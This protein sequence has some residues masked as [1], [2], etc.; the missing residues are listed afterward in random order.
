[1]AQR[2]RIQ[3]IGKCFSFFIILIVEI[4]LIPKRHVPI[5]GFIVHGKSKMVLPIPN[6]CNANDAANA[7]GRDD[8]TNQDNGAIIVQ[9]TVCFHQ[10]L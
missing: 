1:M 2:S 9:F 3:F 6:V 7:Y 4:Y 10:E 5:L 8:K